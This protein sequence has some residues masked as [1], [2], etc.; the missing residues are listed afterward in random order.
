MK[1]FLINILPLVTS[2][3]LVTSCQKSDCK[4]EVANLK[5]EIARLKN[6]EKGKINV[7]QENTN[8]REKIIER[9]DDGN[10]KLVVTYVGNGSQEQVIKKMTYYNSGKIK[11]EENY[12]NNQ[13]NGP[14]YE[15]YR[16]GQISVKT[17]FSNGL[18]HGN[19]TEYYFD[20]TIWETG[21]FVQGDYDGEYNTY[22]VSGQLKSKELYKNGDRIEAVWYNS[23][24]EVEFTN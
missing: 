7:N 18:K 20:G 3:C 17:G 12:R 24:G 10:K 14:Y 13:L 2:L 6:G 5:K 4:K 16:N 22:F 21:K 8:K 9:Y 19:Y 23:N 11:E 15:Y 1:Q